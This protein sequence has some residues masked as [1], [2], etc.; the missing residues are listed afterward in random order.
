MNNFVL[1]RPLEKSKAEQEEEKRARASRKKSETEVPKTIN[2][3]LNS[4][5]PKT[6]RRDREK[7]QEHLAAINLYS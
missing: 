1:T 2:P 3:Q 4:L 7:S 5:L 6:K